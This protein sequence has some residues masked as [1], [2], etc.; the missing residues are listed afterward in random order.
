MPRAVCAFLLF[1]LSYWGF[2]SK[3][4]FLCVFVCGFFGVCIIFIFAFSILF[5]H[6]KAVM[7]KLFPLIMVGGAKQAP[8]LH[9]V[10][11]EEWHFS[12]QR[13]AKVGCG[14]VKY[15]HDSLERAHGM[16]MQCAY[17]LIFQ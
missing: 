16:S 15:V 1:F 4:Q 14:G 3:V 9:S 17:L 10:W 11:H 2:V 5:P 7:Q 8:G 13:V 6:F 12:D